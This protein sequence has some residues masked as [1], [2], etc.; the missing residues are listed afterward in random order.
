ML[1][2]NGIFSRVPPRRITVPALL[3]VVVGSCV[4]LVVAAAAPEPFWIVPLWVAGGVCNGGINV[5]IMVIVAGRTPSAARGRAF[6]SLTASV[7]GAGMIGL[8]AA[9]P[10]VDRVDPRLLVA[11]VGTFGLVTALSGLVVVRREPPSDPVMSTS[12]PPR[13]SVAT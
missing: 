12:R 3:L 9:G 11:V 5:F 2:G 1:L 10:L 7:Q 8:L 13:D 4:P 6:A